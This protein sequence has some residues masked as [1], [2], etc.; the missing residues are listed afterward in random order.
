MVGNEDLA[1]IP[2]EKL[3]ELKYVC[4]KHFEDKYFKKKKAQ[5][6]KTAIP[7]IRL[8]AKQLSDDILS[9]FPCHIFKEPIA[10]IACK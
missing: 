6:K 2:I 10:S 8:T 4:G 1:Y 3:H 7:S 5:L 9:D